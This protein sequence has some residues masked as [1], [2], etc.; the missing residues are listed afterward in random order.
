MIPLFILDSQENFRLAYDP[1]QW[2]LQKNMWTADSR[3]FKD[4][5]SDESNFHSKW[6]VRGEKATLLRLFSELEIRLTPVAQ[7]QF[8]AL[9]DTFVEFYQATHGLPPPW[10]IVNEEDPAE[11]AKDMKK[12]WLSDWKK[13]RKFPG[14]N[15]ATVDAVSQEYVVA[16][17]RLCDLLLEAVQ[18]AA[19]KEGKSPKPV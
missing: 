16:M 18:G 1:N 10:K 19:P 6:Y 3:R 15:P 8:E 2:M 14:V 4:D 5:H 13:P 11:T 7:V 12:I 9:S 17:E